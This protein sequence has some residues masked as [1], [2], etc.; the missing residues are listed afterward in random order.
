MINI[1][2]VL[3]SCILVTLVIGLRQS[4]IGNNDWSRENIG[5]LTELRFPS[6]NGSAEEN[7]VTRQFKSL[8]FNSELGL[9][10]HLN[11][12]TGDI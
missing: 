11:R 3:L 12:K 1:H 6:F 5:K 2:K 7:K 9:F 10:G 4:D 8:F